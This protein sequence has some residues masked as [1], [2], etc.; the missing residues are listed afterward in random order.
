MLGDRVCGPG[1]QVMDPSG[2]PIGHEADPLMH[3]KFKGAQIAR[4]IEV[5]LMM[6][7][8]PSSD[9]PQGRRSR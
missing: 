5:P 4:R 7:S 1:K 6:F 3:R 2:H 8:L 9:R